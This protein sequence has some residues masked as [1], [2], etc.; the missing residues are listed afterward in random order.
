MIYIY[1]VY[2]GI[3]WYNKV[4]YSNIVYY[5]TLYITIL[6]NTKW[7]SLYSMICFLIIFWHM[8]IWRF[9][10][11]SVLVEASPLSHFSQVLMLQGKTIPW[12]ITKL[13]RLHTTQYNTSMSKHDD[14]LKCETMRFHFSAFPLFCVSVRCEVNETHRNSTAPH[15]AIP[16]P[17]MGTLPMARGLPLHRS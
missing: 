2:Y 8:Q 7:Y 4:S 11:W 10:M 3:I 5:N 14:M 12:S 16:N 17:S 1:I 15:Q 9:D 6:G 13:P